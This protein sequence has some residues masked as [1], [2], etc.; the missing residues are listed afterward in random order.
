[1]VRVINASSQNNAEI[2]VINWTKT[3]SIL[4]YGF[5]AIEIVEETLSAAENHDSLF[6]VDYPKEISR[7]N[8]PK[9]VL[10]RARSRIG[11]KGYGP[12]TDNCESFATYCK[13]GIAKSRQAAWFE[14]KWEEI[15]GNARVTLLKDIAKS[16]MGGMS[17][18]ARK[19]ASGEVTEEMLNLL[20]EKTGSQVVDAL[21]RAFP[22]MP[23]KTAME[24]AKKYAGT[25]AVAETIEKLKRAS[26]WVG[27]GV[28]LLLESCAFIRDATRICRE[29]KTGKLSKRDWINQSTQRISEFVFSAITTNFGSLLGSCTPLGPFFGSIIGGAVGS[30]VGKYVGGSV[31]GSR[32]GQKVAL[33]FHE[34]KIVQKIDDL[35]P[36]DHISFKYSK[37]PNNIC[38]AIFIEQDHDKVK[39]IRETH[40]QGVKEE[41]LPFTMVIEVKV[42][43][44]DNACGDPNKVALYA[45]L[46]TFEEC[47]YSDRKYGC[48]T[49][50]VECKIRAKVLLDYY[51]CGELPR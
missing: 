21:K 1:M 12:L 44:D 34:D 46:K 15:K 36:G 35:V 32:L 14:Q 10:A 45:T 31:V 24:L 49:F 19:A 26:D 8:D 7:E 2:V 43:Y 42:E 25:I 28:V 38:H 4:D 3:D 5:D 41:K 23:Q 22:E 51:E 30:F 47:D 37:C 11:D 18:A 39:V 16:V 13:T 17:A 33:Q 27:A 50:A 48:K 9:L 6:R 40:G 29:R 20:L